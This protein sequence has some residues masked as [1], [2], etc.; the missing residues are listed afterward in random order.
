ML[1]VEQIKEH[2]KDP[3]QGFDNCAVCGC[4][5]LANTMKL[6]VEDKDDL[7]CEKCNS[8]ILTYREWRASGVS[9]SK[10]GGQIKVFSLQDTRVFLCGDN[11]LEPIIDNSNECE[12]LLIKIYEDNYV[13]I[14][15][16][17]QK[18]LIDN[19]DNM[20]TNS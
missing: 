13:W 3:N 9:I 14:Q 7:I 18:W 15:Q 6:I 10:S 8:D 19:L 11:K 12:A 17:H 4:V 16:Q 20:E 2:S 5:E 1:T